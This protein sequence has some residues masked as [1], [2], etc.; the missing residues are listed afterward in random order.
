LGEN[1][2]VLVLGAILKRIGYFDMK[3]FDGRLILQ[4]TVYL[5]Q[6]FGLYLG[7][8]FSW[9]HYGPYSPELA[10]NGFS[11]VD[12]FDKIPKGRFVKKSSEKRFSEFLSFLGSKRSDAEWLELL[13]SIHF[14]KRLYPYKSKEDIIDIVTKKQPYFDPEKCRKAWDH[15][16]KHRLIRAKN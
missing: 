13:A 9:Y 12:I 5:L 7:Y 8:R 15:L 1:E 10:S 11:L 16:E 6:A 2:K 4:K 3:S 14:L